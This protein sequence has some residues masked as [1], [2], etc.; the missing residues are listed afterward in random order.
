MNERKCFSEEV[1]FSP[2]DVSV[3]QTERSKD[4]RADLIQEGE[5]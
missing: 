1:M 5:T 4:L 3:G 2:E